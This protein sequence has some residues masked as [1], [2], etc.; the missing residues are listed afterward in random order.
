MNNHLNCMFGLK[1]Y[2]ELFPV[3]SNHNHNA[4]IEVLN[5]DIWTKF[6]LLNI[7]KCQFWVFLLSVSVLLWITSNKQT[8]SSSSAFDLPWMPHVI[9]MVVSFDSWWYMHLP[10][11][12]QGPTCFVCFIKLPG[13]H[14]LTSTSTCT[15]PL[16]TLQIIRTQAC[17]YY[18]C[19]SQHYFPFRLALS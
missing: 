4:N 13:K 19:N 6:S 9:D 8:W 18:I 1:E 7:F 16:L 3:G 12:L 17:P 14:C 15:R 5:Q 10:W 2:A 11:W